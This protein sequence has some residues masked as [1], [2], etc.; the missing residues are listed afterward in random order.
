[1]LMGTVQWKRRTD[2][3]VERENVLLGYLQDVVY[4][5]GMLTFNK[6]RESGP[7]RIVRKTTRMGLQSFPADDS[8][9][10]VRRKQ[11]HQLRIK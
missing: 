4:K 2:A 10:S 8:L 1:M 9:P 11:G 3:A 5:L 7:I 6:G